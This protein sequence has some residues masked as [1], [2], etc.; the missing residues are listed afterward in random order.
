MP[1][2][3]FFTTPVKIAVEIYSGL[4]KSPMLIEFS[5][6]PQAV[7]YASCGNVE[8]LKLNL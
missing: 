5:T 8:N 4:W 6:F 2:E 7:F 1:K 3:M